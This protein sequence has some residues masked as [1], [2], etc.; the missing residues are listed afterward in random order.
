MFP[1]YVK[2]GSLYYSIKPVSEDKLGDD[3]IGDIDKRHLCI[4]LHEDLK[5]GHVIETFLHECC[6]AILDD[7][8]LAEEERVVNL[9]SQAMVAGILDNP[10]I[11]RLIVNKLL[12]EK[13]KCEMPVDK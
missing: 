9:V 1:K 8:E 11:A 5:G 12:G 2:I 13:K 4:Q 10:F 7:L 3:N 6:H